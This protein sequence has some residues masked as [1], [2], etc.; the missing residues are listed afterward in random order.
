MI[1][2]IITNIKQDLSQILTPAQMEALSQTLNKHLT[3]LAGD[4]TVVEDAKHDM[5]PLFIAAKRVEGC[6]EKSLRYYESTIRNMLEDINKPEC[7][8]STEDLRGYLDTYQRRG[9]VSKVT[10][11]NV[12]RILSSFFA[13][14]E[15]E[16][17]IV[18]SPVRRIHKVKTGKTVKET[19]SDCLLYTSPSPRDA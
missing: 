17:Y 2:Q 18:K 11:D 8:I 3:M 16:D 1:N 6:S 4:K 14:L 9:T 7:Q 12:R 10:L 5:L 15:D 13:W 19:Y